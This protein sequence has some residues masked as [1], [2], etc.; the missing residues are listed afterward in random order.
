MEIILLT[1]EEV[2]YRTTF[3]SSYLTDCDII[4]V[5]DASNVSFYFINNVAA[6]G[7]DIHVDGIVLTRPNCPMDV[8]IFKTDIKSVAAPFYVCFC[9]NSSY[10]TCTYTVPKL[11]VFQEKK[12][13]IKWLCGM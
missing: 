8:S 12:Y 2:L 7:D 5:P 9:T 1:K 13:T 3:L 11:Y 6:V 10:Y 4:Y